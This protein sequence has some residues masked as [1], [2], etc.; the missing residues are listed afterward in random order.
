MKL[1]DEMINKISGYIARG[2]YTVTACNLC[3]I[4]EKCFY[5]WLKKGEAS[6][7][8]VYA[9]FRQAIEQ[10]EAEREARLIQDINSDPDWRSKAWLLSRRHP[11]RWGK[12]IKLIKVSKVS[13]ER[14]IVIQNPTI[15]DS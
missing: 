9:K 2:N 8:S 13:Q 6:P 1:N 15:C 12:R 5:E 14:D 3:N 4:S 11:D 7:G 10:A